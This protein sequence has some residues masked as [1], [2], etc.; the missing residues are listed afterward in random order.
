LSGFFHWFAGFGII[1]RGN[2]LS[3]LT[4]YL[5]K[6]INHFLESAISHLIAG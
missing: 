2:E 1:C 3:Q 4:I 5:G 6:Q